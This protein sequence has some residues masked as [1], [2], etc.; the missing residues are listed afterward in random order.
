MPPLLDDCLT[1]GIGFWV[2]IPAV[3]QFLII[4]RRLIKI[5]F[6]ACL[7]DDF[8][9]DQWIKVKECG[10]HLVCP[11][12]GAKSEFFNS[13]APFRRSVVVML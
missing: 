6:Q 9:S 11:Y 5:S 2:Y 12:D 7:F 8:R 13:I 10:V 4:R 3:L 1:K